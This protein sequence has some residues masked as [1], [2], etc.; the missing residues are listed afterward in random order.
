ML[1][2]LMPWLVKALGRDAGATFTLESGQTLPVNTGT[3]RTA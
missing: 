3:R 1:R 2:E